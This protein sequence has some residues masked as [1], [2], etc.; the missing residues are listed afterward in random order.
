MTGVA[1]VMGSDPVT[2]FMIS[3]SQIEL[4]HY[5]FIVYMVQGDVMRIISARVATKDEI[6]HY[7][8]RR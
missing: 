7:Y 4:L 2:S 6:E 1:G 3:Y 8:E 5:L